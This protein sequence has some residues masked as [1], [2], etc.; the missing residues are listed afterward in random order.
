MSDQ[1]SDIESFTD[2]ELLKALAVDIRSVGSPG[3][4]NALDYLENHW[5]GGFEYVL[6]AS[7]HVEPEV[8]G[9][10]FAWSAAV[11]LAALH[12]AAELRELPSTTD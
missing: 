6:K 10:L 9:D 7:V 3:Y 2:D 12:R 4:I 1:P 8:D 11:T 5:P